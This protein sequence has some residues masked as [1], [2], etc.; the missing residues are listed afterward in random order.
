MG[1]TSGV[2]Y[3]PVWVNLKDPNRAITLYYMNQKRRLCGYLK[4]G[5]VNKIRITRQHR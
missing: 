2:W 1:C 4:P 3:I 5:V